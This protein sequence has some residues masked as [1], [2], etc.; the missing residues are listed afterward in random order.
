[1]LNPFNDIDEL[2]ELTQMTVAF[3]FLQK[4]KVTKA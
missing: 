4:Y 3:L 1:M 2:Y